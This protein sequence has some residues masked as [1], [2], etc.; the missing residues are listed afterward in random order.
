M[1]PKMQPDNNFTGR[2]HF[3]LQSTFSTQAFYS[4]FV[5]S[6]L[7]VR[8]GKYTEDIIKLFS[9]AVYHAASLLK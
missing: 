2:K 6:K 5:M 7:L 3:K 8:L 9:L 1:L 4:E